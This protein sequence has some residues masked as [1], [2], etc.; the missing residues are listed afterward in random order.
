MNKLRIITDLA[1]QAGYNEQGKAQYKTLAMK[2]LRRIAKE[3]PLVK[4]SYDIRF[5]PGGIAVAGEATLHHDKFYL[6]T[7]ETGIMFRTCK[8]RK[9]YCG[10]GNNWATGFGHELSEAELIAH[11]R[12]IILRDRV[13]PLLWNPLE[14][15]RVVTQ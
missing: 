1:R 12:A 15:V 4:G 13:N 2:L 5:N 7:S 3:L 6:Q 9:D 11:L 8:G 14:S 10:G